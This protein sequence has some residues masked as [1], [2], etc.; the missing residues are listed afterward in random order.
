MISVC[1]F[2]MILESRLLKWKRWRLTDIRVLS[3]RDVPG[4]TGVVLVLI[5]LVFK[6]G[7][8][9]SQEWDLLI[10]R[11]NLHVSVRGSYPI[12][13]TTTREFVVLINTVIQA[14]AC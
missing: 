11:E 6:K 7:I 13:R 10:N 4:E 2:A 12:C 1:Q 5:A 8:C 9:F 3:R 14:I